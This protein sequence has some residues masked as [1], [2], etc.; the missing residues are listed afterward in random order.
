MQLPSQHNNLQIANESD[1]NN[2]PDGLYGKL[3]EYQPLKVVCV[4]IDNPCLAE[5]FENICREY[6]YLNYREPK[7]EKL[8]YIVYSKDNSVMAGLMFSH[9]AWNLPDREKFIGWKQNV[10]KEKLRYISNNSRFVILPNI[11]VRNL[12]TWILGS[13]SR[14]ISSD[15]ETYYQHPIFALE[16]FVDESR[17]S[18]SCYKA[19]NWTKIGVLKIEN[20]QKTLIGSSLG[21]FFK[22]LDKNSLVGMNR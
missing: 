14:R 20:G 8:R 9:A 11:R 13:I 2:S 4:E 17:H 19:A 22:F 7:G 15:W 12:A 3:S 1:E 5:T 18:G 10:K 6:H 16:T 21:I